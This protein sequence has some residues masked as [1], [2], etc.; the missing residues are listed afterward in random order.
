MLVILAIAFALGAT[1]WQLRRRYLVVTVVGQSM[2]PT[3]RHGQKLLARRWRPGGASYGRLRRSEI[4]VFVP[5]AGAA[6]GFHN[7]L[8][9]RV[10]RV[11]AIAG[12]PV[13]SWLPVL[14]G[15][16][17]LERVPPGAVV[18]RGDNPRSEDSRTYGWVAETSI[19]GL[20]ASHDDRAP[21]ATDPDRG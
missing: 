3:L 18:V 20:V 13:P 8:T 12:D 21:S 14:P 4:I 11:V 17:V 5:P 6:Q 15:V 7:D 16:P 19:L 9:Y 1:I 2:R 10:K